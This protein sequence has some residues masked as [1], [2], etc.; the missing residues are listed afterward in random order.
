MSGRVHVVDDDASF[1]TAIERLLKKAGYEIVA[2]PSAQHL[3]DRMPSESEMGCILVDV[4][5]PGLSGPG[6]NRTHAPQQ[7]ARHSITSSARASRHAN[8]ERL[9][10]LEVQNGSTLVACWTGSSAGFFARQN[11]HCGSP[12]NRRPSSTRSIL[13]LN[14]AVPTN[15]SKLLNVVFGHSFMWWSSASRAC[16]SRPTK[17]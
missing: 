9:R 11:R 4:R 15:G 8:A 12:A 16:C 2:Y 17:A 5:I 10:G 13:L 14:A 1:R 6:H 3:L 7:M